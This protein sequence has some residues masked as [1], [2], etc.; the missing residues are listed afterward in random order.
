MKN[1]F[2]FAYVTLAVAAMA[3]SCSTNAFA[4]TSCGGVCAAGAAACNASCASYCTATGLY[5]TPGFC[6]VCQG[7]CTAGANACNGAC[8]V[9]Q[10]PGN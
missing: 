5:V 2:K 4:A 6:G 10:K 1:I 7:G 9:P 3:V 8:P